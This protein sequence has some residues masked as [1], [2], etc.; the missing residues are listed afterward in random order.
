MTIAFARNHRRVHSTIRGGVLKLK[1]ITPPVQQPHHGT[2][3]AYTLDAAGKPWG[4]RAGFLGLVWGSQYPLKLLN[5]F[6]AHMWFSQ[7]KLQAP[8]P[9]KRVGHPVPA[10]A[11]DPPL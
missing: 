5:Y 10:G 7:V 2:T 1:A 6:A 8:R 3:R 4:S 11:T 9:S